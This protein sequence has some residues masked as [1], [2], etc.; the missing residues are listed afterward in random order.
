ME[1]IALPSILP[2]RT[3]SVKIGR[4]LILSK[5]A[6]RVCSFGV[7]HFV[8]LAATDIFLEFKIT[9]CTIRG[10]FYILARQLCV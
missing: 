7:R 4:F 2:L 9:G 1:C 5:V 8:T 3:I 10:G 6:E